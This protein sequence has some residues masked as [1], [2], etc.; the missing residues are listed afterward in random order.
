MFGKHWNKEFL[1]SFD[2]LIRTVASSP[3]ACFITFVDGDVSGSHH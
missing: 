2:V 3:L 1:Q